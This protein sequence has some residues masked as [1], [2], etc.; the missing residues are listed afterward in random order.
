[1][2]VALQPDKG[3]GSINSGSINSRMDGEDV[4][5][6]LAQRRYAEAFERLLDLYETKVFRMALTFVKDPSRAEEVAQDVFVKLWKALPS[7]DGRAAPG[8]WLFTIARNTC[9]SAVRFNSYRNTIPLV[10][11]DDVRA[12]NVP[13]KDFDLRRCIQRLPEIQRD[14]ILL[15]YFQD[16]SVEDVARMLDMPEN[17]VKSYLRRARQALAAMLKES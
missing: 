2:R 7:Y 3:P 16:Q 10:E 11:L 8:T 15:F 12:A 6:L 1:M 14:V 4:R 13:F 17:T 5:E 9:L